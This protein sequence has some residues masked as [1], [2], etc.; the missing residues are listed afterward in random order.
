M[1]KPEE[2]K[3]DI[4]KLEQELMESK[5]YY[6]WR[7]LCGDKE[8]NDLERIGFFNIGE[9]ILILKSLVD[10][11]TLKLR[12]IHGDYIVKMNPQRNSI[13]VEGIDT[14]VNSEN[15]ANFILWYTRDWYVQEIN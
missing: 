11:N 14:V 8:K 4:N 15:I 3:K 1:R 5:C 10:G 2:I 9:Q 12:C 7:F 13:F 6:E